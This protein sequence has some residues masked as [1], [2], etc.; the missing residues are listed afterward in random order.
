MAR[1]PADS[2]IPLPNGSLIFFGKGMEIDIP[3]FALIY[4]YPF[5][6]V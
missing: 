1:F 2:K 6:I 3:V 4:N 5:S